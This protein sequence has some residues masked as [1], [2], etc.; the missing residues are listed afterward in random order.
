MKYSTLMLA[1]AAALTFTGTTLA[2]YAEEIMTT[3]EHLQENVKGT[4]AVYGKTHAT[5]IGNVVHHGNVSA[6]TDET[7]KSKP[8]AEQKTHTKKHHEHANAK[9][10]E[11]QATK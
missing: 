9:S 7:A 11:P 6:S 2:S 3:E 8:A 1:G 10:V 4:P 5:D